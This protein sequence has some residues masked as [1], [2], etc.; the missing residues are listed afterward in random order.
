MRP[1][2]RSPRCPSAVTSRWALNAGEW[3]GNCLGA[4]GLKLDLG[5]PLVRDVV[6]G[7]PAAVAGLK[8]GDA[9]LS[10]D[11][12]PMRSP[13]DVATV[14]NAHPGERLRFKLRRDG[15]EF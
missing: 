1:S 3:E 11:G 4:L 12:E 9:I 15:G 13:S 6:P 2:G 8:A 7:K 10:I 5:V 14:T